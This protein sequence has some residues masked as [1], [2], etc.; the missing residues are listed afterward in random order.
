[1]GDDA[2]KDVAFG[3]HANDLILHGYNQGADLSLVHHT[4]GLQDGGGG[5]DFVNDRAFDGQN[6]LNSRHEFLD[7]QL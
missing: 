4:S 3:E 7:S 1:M 5:A 2:L 6:I